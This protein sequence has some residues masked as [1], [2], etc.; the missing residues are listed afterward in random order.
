MPSEFILQRTGATEARS[1]KTDVMESP[2][3]APRPSRPEQ[4]HLHRACA[5]ETSDPTEVPL[6]GTSDPPSAG[7]LLVFALCL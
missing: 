4:V 3:P 5:V 7:L 1:D 2:L 6:P